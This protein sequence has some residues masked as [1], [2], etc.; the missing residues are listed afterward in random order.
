MTL[1]G[2]FLF[3]LLFL[4]PTS[5]TLTPEAGVFLDFLESLL[6]L[7]CF[8]FLSFLALSEGSESW[9]EADTRV[10]AE[11]LEALESSP[12]VTVPC[13]WTL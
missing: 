12:Q 7:C 6:S 9:V 10:E 5:V 8:F 11:L 1:L 2:S 4:S 3:L 13:V